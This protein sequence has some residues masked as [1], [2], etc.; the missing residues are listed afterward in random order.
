MNNVFN[1]PIPGE[2][3]TADTKNYPWHRPPDITDLDEA[4]DMASKKLLDEDT[5]QNI[6]TMMEMGIP[7]VT[8]ADAFTTSAVGA[9][10]W[11]IDTAIMLAGPVTHMLII[12]AKGYGIK[13]VVTGLDKKKRPIT[14][15]FFDAQREF[16]V[17]KAQSAAEGIDVEGIQ[18]QAEANVPVPSKG[19]FASANP[20][21]GKEMMKETSKE[22]EEEVV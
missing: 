18:E 19:G 7:L 11:S 2:N 22:G 21:L 9:G 6:I 17:N 8:I 14:K 3:Y 10:K 16:D 1:G 12:L 20:M 13:N 15:A 4:I 5:L